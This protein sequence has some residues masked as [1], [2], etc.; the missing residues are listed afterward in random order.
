MAQ[1]LCWCFPHEEVEARVAM[2]R[3][4]S[5]DLRVVEASCYSSQVGCV[6]MLCRGSQLA[7]FSCSVI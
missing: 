6:L 5:V 7:K 4:A 2:K 3:A 1:G